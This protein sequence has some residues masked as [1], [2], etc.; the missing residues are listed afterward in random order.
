MWNR[1]S[2]HMKYDVCF[3]PTVSW[4]TCLQAKAC[5]KLF[6]NQVW[7]CHT[8]LNIVYSNFSQF[9]KKWTESKMKK[10]YFLSVLSTVN[11]VFLMQYICQKNSAFI[12][13]FKQLQYLQAVQNNTQTHTHSQ[14]HISTYVLISGLYWML[15]KAMNFPE[16]MIRKGK[17]IFLSYVHFPR[18]IFNIPPSISLCWAHCQTCIGLISFYTLLL[19]KPQA[20]K[21][22]KQTWSPHPF[23]SFWL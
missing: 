19:L 4:S 14:T 23:L 7:T 6:Q 11:T 20:F 22:R 16:P 2:F 15:V 13:H 18:I 21:K 3:W 10:I 12:F 17:P 1:L 9:D 8:E 5:L